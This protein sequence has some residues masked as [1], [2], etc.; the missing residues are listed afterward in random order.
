MGAPGTSGSMRGMYSWHSSGWKL[1]VPAVRGEL[2]I[3]AI[4][5]FTQTLFS[6]LK[7]SDDCECNYEELG[8]DPHDECDFVLCC[9]FRRGNQPF[10]KS[11]VCGQRSLRNQ[12]GSLT[13]RCD[14]TSAP[15]NLFGVGVG[16]GVGGLGLGVARERPACRCTCK[17]TKATTALRIGW[18]LRCCG[19]E[20]LPDTQRRSR[21]LCV[22]GTK[23]SDDV[24]TACT[25]QPA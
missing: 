13:R 15:S 17:M 24:G 3:T 14:P 10:F 6:G 1:D 8:S 5:P 16:V 25:L 7:G 23:P 18:R 9:C 4:T 22:S 20:L 2:L 11:L 19:G 12:T 21:Y